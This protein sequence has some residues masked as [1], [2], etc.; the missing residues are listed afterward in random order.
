MRKGA[1]A[2]KRSG[3]DRGRLSGARGARPVLAA[4]A[5]IENSSIIAARLAQRVTALNAMTLRRY[6]LAI[7]LGVAQ[8][9]H[10]EPSRVT[11]LLAQA[12]ARRRGAGTRRRQSR[13]TQARAWP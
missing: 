13:A 8:F 12:I 10:A 4:D 2:E 3:P 7:G 9:D 6:T 5:P 11:D 1:G